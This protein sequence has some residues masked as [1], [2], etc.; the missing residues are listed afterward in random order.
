[1]YYD[2]CIIPFYAKFVEKIFIEIF[3][4]YFIQPFMEQFPEKNVVLFKMCFYLSKKK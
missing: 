2:S 1:M 4:E 3:K